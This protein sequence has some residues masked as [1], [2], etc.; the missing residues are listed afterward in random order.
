MFIHDLTIWFKINMDNIELVGSWDTDQ[1]RI[2]FDD[3]EE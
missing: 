3:E 1:N 2:D